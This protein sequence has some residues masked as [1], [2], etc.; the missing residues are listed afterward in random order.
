M[1]A[2]QGCLQPFRFLQMNPEAHR[3]LARELDILSRTSTPKDKTDDK[4]NV[5]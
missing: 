2:T 3:D 1:W 5:E 4:R